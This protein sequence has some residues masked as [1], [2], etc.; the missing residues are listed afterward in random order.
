MQLFTNFAFLLSIFIIFAQSG[1]AASKRNIT[2]DDLNPG[3]LLQPNGSWMRS[4]QGQNTVGGSFSF[5]NDPNATVSFILPFVSS[6]IYWQG[7]KRSDGAQYWVCLDNCSSSDPYTK[8]ILVDGH[9]DDVR[10]DDNSTTLFAVTGL[11]DTTHMLVIRNGQDERFGGRS[12]ITL[13]AFIITVSDPGTIVN[14]SSEIPRP[15]I[16]TQPDPISP[17]A[18]VLASGSKGLPSY[19]IIL[20]LAISLAVFLIILGI[21]VWWCGFRRAACFGRKKHPMPTKQSHNYPSYSPTPKTGLSPKI[22][23]F[24]EDLT[25]EFS[26]AIPIGFNLQ[27]DDDPS[28]GSEQS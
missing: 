11:L 27:A 18:F 14:V 4:K 6:A 10:L 2:I 17:T 9:Q 28:M 25:Q 1:L 20:T 26:T 23:R 5:S 21:V 15:T 22:V 16:T 13:D 12:Q 8:Y 24:R 3:I 19:L 7:F